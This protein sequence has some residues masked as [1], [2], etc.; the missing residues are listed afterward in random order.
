MNE[1]FPNIQLI[2]LQIENIKKNLQKEE[3]LITELAILK[4]FVIHQKLFPEMEEFRNIIFME[5]DE[6]SKNKK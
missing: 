1:F 2:N 4:T 3:D 5:I 6:F